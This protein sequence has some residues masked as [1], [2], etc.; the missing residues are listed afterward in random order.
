M[1]T[2]V[3]INP[4][5]ADEEGVRWNFLSK[6][7]L[8]KKSNFPEPSGHISNCDTAISYGKPYLSI[9][10][11]SRH[12]DYDAN[13]LHRMQVFAKG[14]A[15]QCKRFN[16]DAELIIV[17]WN[18]P[19]DRKRLH[20]VLDWPDDLGPL[21]V[22]FIEV[23]AEIHNSIGNSDK[24]PFF[25][26]IAKN[27]GI[28][29]ARG[30]FVLATNID[31]LFSNKLMQFL[32][33][34]RLDENCFY[35]ID[36]HDVGSKIL[37]ECKDIN[38]Q[39][40][41]CRN[42][43]VR[44]HGLYGTKKISEM[45]SDH[46][47][48]DSK[49]KKLHT[50]GCGDFTLMSRTNWHL[51]RAYPELRKWSIYVDGLLLHMAYVSGLHQVILPEPMR[52]YHI[53]HDMSWAVSDEA[54]QKLTTERYPTCR[55]VALSRLGLDYQKE[56]LVWC[57]Q[58]TEAGKPITNNNEHWGYAQTEF[59]ECVISGRWKGHMTNRNVISQDNN[60]KP[61]QEWIDTLALTQNRLY[62]RDQTPK[63]LNMLLELVHRYKPTKIVELGTLSGLSLRAWLAAKSKAEVIA[64]DLSFKPLV[65]SQKVLPVELSGVRL[66]EQDILK[67]DFGRFWSEEDRVILYVDAH[68]TPNAPIMA[69]VLNNAVP[70]LPRSH[71]IAVDDLW[72]CSEQVSER[73]VS[74]F[75]KQVV[76]KEIDYL[77]CFEGYYA[78][79][80]KGGFFI[81]FPE[82][83]PLMEWVNRNKVDLVFEPGG[84][85][86]MFECPAGPANAAG[87]GFDSEGFNRLTGNLHHNPVD[88]IRIYEEK[89][90]AAGQQAGALC[91][92]AIELFAAS[93][94]EE[95]LACL[96]RA[97]GLTSNISGAFYGMGV[98]LVRLG[99]FDLAVK[100]LESEVNS[101]FAHPNARILYEDVKNHAAGEQSRI[102]KQARQGQ[103]KGF[104]IFAMPKAFTGLF[105]TIQRNAMESWVRLRPSPEIILLGDDDG[106]ADAAGRYGCRH[107]P[108][109]E[110]NEFG[111]PLLDDIFQKAQAAASNEICVYVNA[112]IIL[113]DN[114]AEAIGDVARRFSQFLMVG[115][116]WDIDISQEIDF[117]AGDWQQRL[118]EQVRREGAY[119]APTG[120]DYF[121]FKKG[122]W[123]KI[124]PLALG[125]EVWDNW[126]VREALLAGRPVIDASGKV[127]IVHQNHDFSHVPGGKKARSFD[128][129]VR[130]N[131][132]M[133]GNDRS[134]A[135]TSHASWELTPAGIALRP[136]SEF[137]K[138][139][140]LSA[141]LKCIE[142]SYRQAPEIV[143]GQCEALGRQMD[144]GLRANLLSAAKREVVS[145]SAK[146][147]ANG[148]GH[149]LRE[150]LLNCLEME[151]RPAAENP[152]EKELRFS[153]V[154]IVLN[155]MPFIEYSLKSVYDFAHE[156]IIV[157]GA[158]ENCM[159]AAG[160]DGSSTDGTV[161]FIK[162]F[163]DP[164]KKVRLIQGRWPE[165]CEMQNEA[166]KYVTGDYVWLIDSDEVYKRQDLEKVREIL[167]DDSSITQVNFI[168]DNFWKGFDYIFVSSK[169]FEGWCHYRRLFK[170]VPGAMFTTHR[171]PTMV[172][173]GC[174][175]TTEQ[176]HLLDG[177]ATR[178]R[179]IILY[180][181]SYVLDKQVKQ[182]IELYHRYGWGRHW[183]LDL[184][185]WYEECFLK[186]TPENRQQID[187]Q[188]PIWTGDI[189]S[190]TQL[191]TGTHPEVMSNF[192]EK[193]S[194]SKDV[195]GETDCRVPDERVVRVKSPAADRTEEQGGRASAAK[196]GSILWVR[197][198]SIG[199]GVL[200]ASMLPYI[201]RKYEGARIVV[202]C[203]EHIAE[204]YEACPYVDEVV[205]FNRARALED[206]RYR[207]EITA[208]LRMLKPQLSLNSVYSREALTD[209][210]TIKCGA[211]RRVAL[212]G[213]LC[214]ISP[215]RRG[216]HNQ[217]YTDLL[218][219]PG[220]H[221]L[222]LERHRDFLRGLDIEAPGL[223]PVV[224]IKQEDEAFADRMF[225]EN[226]LDPART[227]ALFAGAQYDCRVYEGYGQAMSEFC[228]ANRLAVIALGTEQDRDINQRNLDAIGVR[229][230]N[231]S[232]GTTILQSCAILKRCRL[233]VGAETGLAHI[234]CAVG[235]PN[236]ILLGGG[237]FG[238]FMPYSPLTSVACLP[239]ECYGCNWSCRYKSSYCVKDVATEVV[240]Q[241]VRRSF[242]VSSQKIRV[243]MQGNSLWEAQAGR[244][245]WKTFEQFLQSDNIQIVPVEGRG[246]ATASGRDSLDIR[247]PQ[248]EGLP[249]AGSR[250]DV[251][252]H[253][254]ARLTIATSIAP[255][256]PRA[257][258]G[259]IE[260]QARAIESWVKLG[261]RPVSI[262]CIEEIDALRESFPQVEFVPA[263][264]DAR[265]V[266]G[267]PLIYF[268]DFLE[269]FRQGDFEFG[270]IVNSDIF[271]AGDEGIIPFIES[272]ARDSL[273]YGSRINVDSLEVLEGEVYEQGFDF[274]FFNKSLIP[275][276]PK[277][278][279]CIGATWWDYWAPLIAALEGFQIKRLV[280]PFAYH[281]RHRFRWDHKQWISLAQKCFAYLIDKASE[282][283]YEDPDTNPWALLAKIFYT[284]HNGDTRWSGRNDKMLP[285]V[286]CSSILEFLERKSL[287]IGYAK[288]RPPARRDGAE[289]V[290][291]KRDIFIHATDSAMQC[292]A[293]RASGGGADGPGGD[294]REKQCDLSIVLCTKDRAELL[295]EMLDSLE[296]AAAGAAYELMVVKGG[297]RDNTLDVLRKHGVTGVYSESEWL[298]PQRH[299]WPQLYN[300]GFSK[301]RGKWAM[302]ASDDIVFGPGAVTRALEVLERQ[303]EDVAGGIF[304]YRNPRPTRQDWAEYG[305]DFTDGARLLMNYGL[306][307]L[308]SF[309]RV[310][311][312]DEAYRF[313]CADTD[314]CHKLYEA[315]WQLIP[316]P[317]CFVTHNDL[318]DA[319]KQANADAS[320]RDI[321]L[322][323]R[324]W[325]HFIRDDTAVPM[326]L[327]WRDDL[328]EAFDVPADLEKIDSGPGPR[329]GIESFWRG[330]ACFQQ[331]MFGRAEQEFVE[332]VKSFCDHKQVLWW[333][334][335]AA[336]KC[337]DEG[338]AEKAA[339]G[340]VRLAPDFEPGLDLL[341]RVAG[342]QSS[343]DSAV[344][345]LCSAQSGSV[346]TINNYACE[347]A[348]EMSREE[349]SLY[350]ESWKAAD[351]T[352]QASPAAATMAKT[353]RRSDAVR[354]E[355][356][357]RRKLEKFNK[358]VVW[359]LKTGG[360]TH[361]HIHRHFFNTLK[362]LDAK[363][364]LVDDLLENK[365]AIEGSDLVISVDVA[366]RHLPIRQGVYY[367]LHN[368]EDDIHQRID[369]SKN[370]RLRT[371][372][373]SAE[374]A[375]RCLGG[376]A[377][378]KWDQVTFFDGKTR[379]LFQPWATDLLAG[380]FE[381]PILKPPSNI[382]FWVGSIW[383]DRLNRGN[384][385]EIRILK[386][387]LEKRDIRFVHLQGI[388]DLLNVRYVRH[389]LI[390]PAI[391]GRWQVENDYLPCRMWKNISYGQ[392]GVS[393]VKKFDEV[394]N[395]CTVTGRSIEEI[396]DNTLSLPF[397]R[398]RDMIY[399][400]QEVVKSHH[401]YVN[402][403]LNI[404]RAFESVENY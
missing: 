366:S 256:A 332:A 403:L 271:L 69:H 170:Y 154:M 90:V 13:I 165:K 373:R 204:L 371:Y 163:P 322:C 3:L 71:V 398:Y 207:L 64:I 275:R 143:A 176:M 358:V 276:I 15:E 201:R 88:Q 316:L 222:E 230:I 41:F 92:R 232:G 335:Q 124:P 2:A 296:E 210:F 355:T 342:R 66:L 384:V 51:F 130:R 378:E 37:P 55:A 115:R 84:K 266:F 369:P 247:T 34:G 252:T 96:N 319:Q 161:E 364:V 112:D 321:E 4:W 286:F 382:V 397:G 28:R 36:R 200:S 255:K 214:N 399:E 168:P 402:R 365:D 380:E 196:A 164:R 238:R 160:P 376:Q 128:I 220:G 1:S 217:F 94:I 272:Q 374:Q 68:D 144:A 132:D 76:A 297:S 141:A 280:G 260:K 155:G 361:A 89:D 151:N 149:P 78:P 270:G 29:R 394:F 314:L 226:G 60:R 360:H 184:G 104:T 178:E 320:G 133:A 181:Y 268:D 159:F 188:Y 99:R 56:Y 206:E 134:L 25:Q 265:E 303:K 45:E 347:P 372:T 192:I 145:G 285:G 304:F 127:T 101:R 26:M 185:K 44:V 351:L 308:E 401:T 16:L 323:R 198:D 135:Y 333:L 375:D 194:R 67:T 228:R 186:W 97:A 108:K 129:E 350:P 393:N 269:Y 102:S 381:E 239:L 341:I 171:P 404:I 23:P 400:Q 193:Y 177:T 305:I 33:S 352:N 5:S 259:E 180:H 148:P 21:T 118:M 309:R 182:K 225:G 50:N 81:G 253:A 237:H 379:T 288:D 306:V 52:I 123:P 75:F 79:Y 111:T 245:K 42:N 59:K 386:D 340:V 385:N 191:F 140:N 14:L 346:D 166:L 179:G 150:L 293:A 301:A 31:I 317:G 22:R 172:W 189:N 236:V 137:L 117:G 258:C 363:V 213:N 175:K 10:V 114:F 106:V 331:G 257:P 298:G 368:C 109:V 235:T 395:G 17:E 334:A 138:G 98:C 100:M 274:F 389:S 327:L 318:L 254:D 312:F 147:A 315:G 119:H 250:S 91:R 7:H 85:V 38:K 80:W 86:V 223:Q 263:K 377:G 231:L 392:F 183:N 277:T 208:R 233:A 63:S 294:E 121:A 311:G 329:W 307:R 6:E 224:W 72:Y 219:S 187:S 87:E 246:N 216:M 122:L 9:V 162:S 242:E 167:N 146:N 336:D 388:S 337:H 251:E 348:F 19:T 18:P 390:A 284:N 57:R 211:E 281:V 142:R 339:T 65:R 49:D 136:I 302:Y 313:Y 326:R 93:R 35:R 205:V 328:S 243:F 310:G 61:F 362:K 343:G 174:E 54:K 292:A 249:D 27:V 157:E 32:A 325:S 58:M 153:F 190:R 202:V 291:K 199:D 289:P 77:G 282:N 299:S 125:R 20:E 48:Y 262:N 110:R 273:V 357:L 195:G 283:F 349:G 197:T 264:R 113:M 248:Q 70:A 345:V 324:R 396:I 212:E 120:I 278:E 330:L 229:T 261:F 367:C 40:E 139:D 290:K 240:A 279:F 173:P 300:F 218:P 156:I 152:I 47:I 295:D 43:I 158:V 82:V 83:V 73:S 62:Y 12:D 221:K 95:A 116:R 126:L 383:S 356:E 103:L 344:P 338:L 39:L 169:F 370:I 234:C 267:K 354:S 30:K 105:A 209:W 359:G 244:P 287:R 53:E 203:Q 215:E 387:A 8:C 391:A 131:L 74:E 227:I 46:F 11:A 353:P 24:L 241:A 107:I